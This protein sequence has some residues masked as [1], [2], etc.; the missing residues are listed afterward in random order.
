MKEIPLPVRPDF[1]AVYEENYS[2]VYNYVYRLLLHPQN[3]EDVV[4]EAFLKALEAWPRYDGSKAS[5]STWLC[6]I[7]HHC[8]MNFLSSA[9][10]SR[11]V[12]LDALMEEGALPQEMENPWAEDSA[13]SAV[14]DILSRLSLREREFLNLRY[15]MEL[16]NGEIAER[17]GITEKAV[18][19]RYRRL[20]SK[21]RKIA[22]ADRGEAG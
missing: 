16:S 10:Q 4:S 7:A 21:C 19:D 2:K 17:L 3:T 1:Q 14:W 22:A 6:T 9:A 13:E 8:A 15:G 18:S 11:G 20:L 12:S 5:P